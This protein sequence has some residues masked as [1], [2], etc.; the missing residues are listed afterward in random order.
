MEKQ[1]NIHIQTNYNLQNDQKPA[2]QHV[3]ISQKHVWNM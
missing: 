3:Q 2:L 1:R